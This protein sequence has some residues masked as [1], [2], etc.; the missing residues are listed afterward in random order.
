MIDISGFGTGITIV[1]LQTF[2]MGFSVSQFADDIDPIDAKEIAAVGYEM[3]FDGSPFFY[4]KASVIEVK[5]G[6]IA[7]SDDDLNLKTLLQVKKGTVSILPISDVTTMVV[8]YPD[9]GRVVLSNGSIVSGP[10][11]DS[12]Q[13]TGRKKGNTYTFAFGSF[14]GAQSAAELVS[15]IASSALSLI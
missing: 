14:M 6:V 10:L 7:G 15:G 8:T 4:D 3:L 12:I 11:L 1:A 13:A 2:P 9:K 5:I